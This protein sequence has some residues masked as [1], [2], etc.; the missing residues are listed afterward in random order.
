VLP[1]ERLLPGRELLFADKRG[2]LL[3]VIDGPD[4]LLERDRRFFVLSL[5]PDLQVE[6]LFP[7]TRQVFHI[8]PFAVLP[9]H[10]VKCHLHHRLGRDLH[11]HDTTDDLPA[12]IFRVHPL[13]RDGAEIDHRGAG[14]GKVTDLVPGRIDHE[15][16]FF[17][18]DLTVREVFDRTGI[19]G[20]VRDPALAVVVPERDVIEAVG[21][22]RAVELVLRDGCQ[23]LIPDRSR[24]P[25][26]HQH[27]IAA[28]GDLDLIECCAV[29]LRAEHV[30]NE[31]E[32]R[33]ADLHLLVPELVG[34][35]DAGRVVGEDF[36]G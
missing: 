18:P 20:I 17:I 19:P 21:E 35:G 30:G 11:L 15:P 32:D 10:A 24:K 29:I 3:Q 8:D 36:V 23:T 5:H 6:Q 12:N 9:G 28:A 27:V 13:T 31:M 22:D 1:D 7:H 2:K 16:A 33:V 34:S 14:Q 25:V 26:S 4:I